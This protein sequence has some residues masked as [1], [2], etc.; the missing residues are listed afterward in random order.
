MKLKNI[1]LIALAATAVIIIVIALSM[2]TVIFDLFSYTATGSENLKPDGSIAGK[3]LV[4]Y[5][6]G[7]SGMTKNAA[8]SIARGLESR[9]YD[10]TVA[11]IRSPEASKA[12]GYDMVIVGSPTY[13]GNPTGPV[14]DYLNSVQ[15]SKE[16]AIGVFA[17]GM[18]P[19]GENP[20]DSERV[21]AGILANRSINAKAKMKLISADNMEH[22]CGDFAS[23]MTAS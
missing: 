3:A 5:D 13:A 15:P 18:S 8:Y 23:R 2:G 19:E 14:T 7:I 11:G 9:A 22:K 17:T 16:A 20:T 12:S 10:V 6:P 21:M 4:V 1:A